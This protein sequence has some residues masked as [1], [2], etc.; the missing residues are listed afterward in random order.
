MQTVAFLLADQVRKRRAEASRGMCAAICSYGRNRRTFMAQD[1]LLLQS[2]ELIGYRSLGLAAHPLTS[3]L[4]HP[5]EF[6]VDIHF[7]GLA[8][9]FVVVV[10]CS[11]VESSEYPVRPVYGGLKGSTNVYMKLAGTGSR[12]QFFSVVCFRKRGKHECCDKR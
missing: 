1:H 7:G 12:G 11:C 5:V 3:P 9:V 2:L 8:V 4:L 10:L 6:L